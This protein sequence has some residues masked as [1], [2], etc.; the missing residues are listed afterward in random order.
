MFA[1]S[2]SFVISALYLWVRFINNALPQDVKNTLRNASIIA[3]NRVVFNIKGNDHR[4]SCAMDYP[5][6]AMFIKFVGTHKEYDR[7]N[8]SEVEND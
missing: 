2:L 3:N 4:I 7:V 1:S 5:R 6:L 8:A